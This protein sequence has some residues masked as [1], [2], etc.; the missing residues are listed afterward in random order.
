VKSWMW[1]FCYR[2]TATLTHSLT[3]LSLSGCLST[4]DQKL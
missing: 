2:I 4:W 1:R 3:A